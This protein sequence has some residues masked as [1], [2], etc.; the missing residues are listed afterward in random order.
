MNAFS[1]VIGHDRVISVLSKMMEHDT[2][3][4]AFVFV[5]N[6]GVGRTTVAQALIRSL[7]SHTG[8]LALHPDVHTLEVLV[9]E[10]T[11]KTKTNI[12]VEQVRALTSRVAM[13]PMQGSWKIVWI[14]QA[15][16]LSMG[17]ANA[18]LKTLEEPK[19]KMLFLLR[20]P[21][22][23]TLPATIVSRC[24]T[25]R[26][27]QV[28]STAI[29]DGLTM[30]GYAPRDAQEATALCQ[31]R[32]GN[33]VRFLKD[34]AY[35]SDLSTGRAQA[36]AFVG[37]TITE[38]LGQVMQLIPKT[39]ANK[40]ARLEQVV[41]Y[42]QAICREQLHE[43]ISHMSLQDAGTHLV[44]LPQVKMLGRCHDVRQALSSNINPHLAL[45]HIA[46]S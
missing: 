18:L 23:D 24:Q 11:G 42:L 28:A 33:A 20:A 38:R 15:H 12:S 14:E 25:L 9:D 6:E 41:G 43:A 1:G 27:A 44:Q 5:G 3:P 45:E 37:G 31:G 32:P 29:A 34:S 22:I 4:H 8:D 46:L 30:L 16:T 36:Q 10:K 39:E 13:S 17:A 40:A 7:L 2:L 35:R 19:G 26:F 21:E